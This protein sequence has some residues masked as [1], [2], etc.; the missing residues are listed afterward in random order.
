MVSLIK[1]DWGVRLAK[2]RGDGRLG[3]VCL[4]IAYL[5][6]A[7]GVDGVG[8]PK[9][10]EAFLGV[11]E[12]VFILAHRASFL[13]LLLLAFP[14]LW[15]GGLPQEVLEELVVLVEVFD[16]IGVV[17]STAGAVGTTPGV[18]DSTAGVLGIP[19]AV[20]GTPSAVLDTPLRVLGTAPGV[21]GSV[22]GVI[23]TSSPASPPPWMTMRST[24]K[25]L[26]KPSASPMPELS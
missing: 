13:G 22:P 2:E 8:S 20:L 4:S 9:D 3:G 18:V 25:V 5:V 21:L 23:G 24:T 6:L 1:S 26:V 7:L 16:T 10:H 12:V 11:G 14:F 15:L 17:G 19:S